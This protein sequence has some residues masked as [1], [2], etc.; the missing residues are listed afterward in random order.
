MT[1]ILGFVFS[2]KSNKIKSRDTVLVNPNQK[3]QIAK[4]TITKNGESINLFKQ[5]NEWFGKDDSFVFLLD[6]KIIDN[7]IENMTQEREVFEL[8]NKPELYDTYNLTESKATRI[9]FFD[10]NENY[11]AD[12]YFGSNNFTA[13]RIRLRSAKTLTIYE[14]K[15]NLYQFLQTGYKYWADMQIFASTLLKIEESS[16]LRIFLDQKQ[17]FAKDETAFEEYLSTLKSCRCSFFLPKENF[18]NQKP[19]HSVKIETISNDI[20]FEI[21]PNGEDYAVFVKGQNHAC[22]ISGWTLERIIQQ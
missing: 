14:T 16:I 1:A 4:I 15:D 18:S 12:L 20:D 3:E 11:I 6:K 10:S 21:Y 13:S 17:L 5:N 2:D 22:S 7:F 8:S 9:C 19:I